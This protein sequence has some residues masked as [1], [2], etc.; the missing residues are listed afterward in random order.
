MP[1]KQGFACR[2]RQNP[3][4]PARASQHPAATTRALRVTMT[5]ITIRILETFLRVLRRVDIITHGAL[6]FTAAVQD[7]SKE[8]A[9]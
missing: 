7:K 5:P 4:L 1:E 3:R 8:E 9:K 6:A 2:H